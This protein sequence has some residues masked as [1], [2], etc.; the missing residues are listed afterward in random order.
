[1]SDITYE[2]WKN[3]ETW[4]VALWINNDF[5]LYTSATKFMKSYK[6]R[7][8]YSDWIRHARLQGKRLIL[9]GDEI[10]FLSKKLSLRELNQM[11]RELANG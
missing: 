6:G 1:M 8:P 5:A 2:G 11:M 4:N 9:T 10:E 7:S 3:Y